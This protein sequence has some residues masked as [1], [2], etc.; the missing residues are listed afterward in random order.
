VDLMLVVRQDG[1]I[2]SAVVV[3][4][5]PMLQPAALDSARHTLFECRKCSDA[6]NSYRLVY[7]FQVE[8]VDSC[9]PTDDKSKHDDEGQAY[10]RISD[11]E[12]RVTTTAYLICNIDP[13][14]DFRKSRSLKCLYLWRCG[15]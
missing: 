5:P 11:A 4:G 9:M 14:S 3:S 13:A 10:P 2:E 7:T 8:D 6:E 1:S 12:H 15:S